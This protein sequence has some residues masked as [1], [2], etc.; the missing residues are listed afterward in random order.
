MLLD[1][2]IGEDSWESLGLQGDPSSPFWSRSALDFFGRNDA[3]AETPALWPRE[4]KNWL[5]GKCPDARKEWRQEKKGMT[6]DEMVGRHHRFN[7]HEFEQTQGSSEGQKSLVC[8]SPWGCKELDMTESLNN[9]SEDE[10]ME[11]RDTLE[12]EPCSDISEG[13]TH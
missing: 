9:K 1:C 3:K 6:E 13:N 10:G 11:V 4:A 2:G 5:I 8:Y 12:V 7:G